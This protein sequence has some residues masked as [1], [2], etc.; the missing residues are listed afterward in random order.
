MPA[1]TAAPLLMTRQG[2]PA[3]PSLLQHAPG[4][5]ALA[6]IR[7]QGQISAPGSPL[8]HSMSPSH[9]SPLHGS[10]ARASDIS[11]S[12]VHVALEAIRP[13][14]RR[15][16][17]RV[18]SGAIFLVFLNRGLSLIGS[19][20]KVLPVTAYDKDGVRMLLNFASDC[21]PGRPDVLVMVVSMLNTAPLPVHNVQL[22]AAVPKVK[23]QQKFTICKDP[24]FLFLLSNC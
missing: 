1:A 2:S 24:L 20:G 9:P 18:E 4:S 23:G 10:P 22:Q 5:P 19:S 11:L 15:K 8:F 13:S 6:H 16:E 12:N 21:P 7:A 14:K 3:S 17:R